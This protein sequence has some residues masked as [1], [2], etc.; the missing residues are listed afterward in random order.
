[1]KLTVKVFL[2]FFSVLFIGEAI[3]QT[4]AYKLSM[5][6][7]HRISEAAIEGL[8]NDDV[9]VFRLSSNYRK[10][11][12]I[13]RLY[14][15]ESDEI[16]RARFENM[17]MEVQEKTK[18]ESIILI[19]AFDKN[20]EFSEVLFL[21]DTAMVSLNSGVEKGIFLNENL[22]IDSSIELKGRNYWVSYFGRNPTGQT[23]S[24]V[25]GFVTMN[26]ELELLPP[27]FPYFVFKLKSPYIFMINYEKAYLNAAVKKFNKHL[28]EYHAR[29]QVLD[30]Y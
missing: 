7:R 1:M 18:K 19:N 2:M 4:P 8:H 16:K 23:K 24:D 21:Y 29:A 15:N 22:E 12:E 26:S 28:D 11:Q 13:E 17:L 14:S 20:Y 6:D 25:E 30:K 5:A 9:L 10:I 27:P 3:A